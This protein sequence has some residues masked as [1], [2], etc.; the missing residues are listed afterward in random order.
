MR[1]ILIL[2]VFLLILNLIACGDVAIGGDGSGSCNSVSKKHPNKIVVDVMMECPYGQTCEAKACFDIAYFLDSLTGRCGYNYELQYVS[3]DESKIIRSGQTYLMTVTPD[4][5]IRFSLFD[6]RK[7]E[8]KYDID[9]SAIIQ[10]YTVQGDSIKIKLPT[11]NFDMIL[12]CP[13][14]SDRDKDHPLCEGNS[15][16]HYR[17]KSISNVVIGTDSTWGNYFTF[18]MGIPK[19]SSSQTDSVYVYG[20]IE[21]RK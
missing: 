4:N 20:M 16:C 7:V 2:S 3:K 15:Q 18:H 5:Y 17:G 8:K 19:Q 10:S 11:K 1:K 14:C 21:F 13:Y 6:E 12:K 9:L